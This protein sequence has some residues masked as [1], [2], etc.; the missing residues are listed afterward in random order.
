MV[1]SHSIV[2]QLAQC[3]VNHV[4]LDEFG[5]ETSL[6]YVGST[7]KLVCVCQP[8]TLEPFLTKT[9][10]NGFTKTEGTNEL[11][12]RYYTTTD[13]VVTIKVTSELAGTR[14]WCQNSHHYLIVPD[15]PLCKLNTSASYHFLKHSKHLMGLVLFQGIWFNFFVN[16]NYFFAISLSLSKTYFPSIN[17]EFIGTN[18]S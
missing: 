5:D 11:T 8:G 7:L 1:H 14:Y 9:I 15:Q 3:Q 18:F 4:I 12:N 16:D 17:L 2:P 6:L 10:F 13:G